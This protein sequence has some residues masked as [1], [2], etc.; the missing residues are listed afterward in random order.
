LSYRDPAPIPPE[1]KRKVTI[2]HRIMHWFTFGAW[3]PVRVGGGALLLTC[4]V[5]G[6]KV[7]VPRRKTRKEA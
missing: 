6:K 3:W 1:P 2:R 4:D 7:Y 5:C